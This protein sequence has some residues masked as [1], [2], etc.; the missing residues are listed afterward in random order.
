MF[1]T[2]SRA[3]RAILPWL[4]LSVLSLGSLDCSL[5]TAFSDLATESGT[6]GCTDITSECTEADALQCTGGHVE[7]CSADSE[8][9]LQWTVDSEC[10]DNQTCGSSSGS[11]ACQC[12]EDCTSGESRCEDGGRQT[13]GT[14]EASCPEWQDDPCGTG[15]RC[16][17]SGS[18]A[19]CVDDDV[20]EDSCET[21]NEST[22]EDSRLMTCRRSEAGCLEA[23][24]DLDC[25]DFGQ[26][27]SEGACVG[28][29]TDGCFEL[30]ASRCDGDTIERC[31]EVGECLGWVPGVACNPGESCVMDGGEAHCTPGCPEPCDSGALACMGDRLE[32]CIFVDECWRWTLEDDCASRGEICDHV[33]QACRFPCTDGCTDEGAVSCD[34]GWTERCERLD[35]GCLG[36]VRVDDCRSGGKICLDGACVCDDD[37]PGTGEVQCRD[38]VIEECSADPEGCLHWLDGEDCMASGRFCD[39]G[40]CICDDACAATESPR[41]VGDWV[42]TCEPD[43]FGCSGWERQENCSDMGMF[44]DAGVCECDDDCPAPGDRR[45]AGPDLEQCVASP[46]GCLSWHRAIECQRSHRICFEGGGGMTPECEPPRR[47]DVCGTSFDLLPLPQTVSGSDFYSD[48]SD[49]TSMTGTGCVT[50]D[51]APEVVFERWMTSVTTIDVEVSGGVATTI[52]F[53]ES[54]CGWA[55]CLFSAETSTASFTTTGDR[56]VAVIVEVLE[57]STSS[58]YVITIDD[59]GSED[60]DDGVDNDLDHASDCSDPDCFGDAASCSVEG[61]CHDGHDNDEDGAIDCEDGDCAG[62]PE[63][64]PATGIFEAFKRGELIDL[65]GC[66]IVF[67]PGATATSDYAVST[68]CDCE[69]DWVVEPGSG[70]ESTELE[71]MD[72]EAQEYDLDHMGSVSFYGNDYSS[73]YV[74]ANGNVTLGF[75]SWTW[76]FSDPGVFFDAPRIAPLAVDLYP[77]DGGTI[78]VDEDGDQVAVT[79]QDIPFLSDRSS[80]A[81][82]QLVIEST[83]VITF[84][85]PEVQRRFVD[86]GAA[87]GIGAG[88]PRIVLPEETNFN[89]ALPAP[90]NEGD[91]FMTE[92]HFDPLAVR[93]FHGEFV[94]LYNLTDDDFELSCCF[95]QASGFRALDLEGATILSGDHLV[96]VQDADATAN[97]GIDAGFPIGGAFDLGESSPL[98]LTL[99]CRGQTIDTI[100]FTGS[101]WPAGGEG[102]SMQLGAFSY[103]AD[104][105][106]NGRSWCDSTVAWDPSAGS[107][108]GSPGGWNADCP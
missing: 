70:D 23:V 101:A 5:I 98:N 20:C 56:H 91:L 95:L 16:E 30:D 38:N 83:G 74:G 4:A 77:P 18:G 25:V 13:C 87:T 42:Q 33:D 84:V 88:S 6:A 22:C 50:S 21:E 12:S 62:N 31:A 63:C 108:L 64:V 44:C 96:L 73:L 34:G 105:N 57:S 75:A 7:R 45:C 104:A 81:S 92:I 2:S 43:D 72:D 59:G 3:E 55:E 93:D 49:S 68:S 41:C 14:D 106:D 71:L 39:S 54:G 99:E 107:D 61:N 65:Q 10:A 9:C 103:S 89:D 80:I 79:W 82:M 67:A 24:E 90:F 35:H 19:T 76:N 37:C 58:D 29:C 66:T 17:D 102:T 94:E 100:V 46:A 28:V 85:Y 1:T 97:G 60:C 27:C 8:G 53:Q 15:L 69:V 52:S 26:E 47:G 11:P 78:T 48:F 36:I 32:Q 40:A 86:T 51:G